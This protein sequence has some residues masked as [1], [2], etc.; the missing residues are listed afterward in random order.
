[1]CLNKSNHQ[2]RELR[3]FSKIDECASDKVGGNGK[4]Q[5]MS[6]C[7]FGWSQNTFARYESREDAFEKTVIQCVSNNGLAFAHADDEN[8]P[9]TRVRGM[10][11][12]GLC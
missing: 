8:G 3:L 12:V 7:C 11:I 2:Y 4:L 10:H 9:I 1:M 5:A 6:Q